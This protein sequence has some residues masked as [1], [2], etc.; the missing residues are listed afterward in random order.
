MSKK[1][2]ISTLLGASL[3]FATWGYF[4][5]QESDKGL[6]VKASFNLGTG[7]NPIAF[8]LGARYVLGSSFEISLMDIGF[9]SGDKIPLD[10]ESYGDNE[11]PTNSGL[12]NPVL[13]VRYQFT[14]K[15]GAFVD[16]AIPF[17]SQEFAPGYIYLGIQKAF[18]LNRHFA[19][20]NEVGYK[21]FFA[22]SSETYY[23]DT[24]DVTRGS[25]V[26]VATEL[27]F[28]KNPN[29]IWFVG[30]KVSWNISETNGEARIDGAHNL[31]EEGDTGI[32][33]F[34]GA[35]YKINPNLAIE[36]EFSMTLLGSGEFDK[37]GLNFKTSAK[38]AF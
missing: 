10:L 13:G 29:F 31:G 9:V 6:Q 7:D 23:G 37:S 1:I 36:E 20:G 5:L 18:T 34:A 22:V 28:N 14:R 32:D 38:Y 24:E 15:F 8:G 16:L 4:P 11:L 19:W 21:S 3:S 26:L 27:D 35:S 30:G 25:Q 33:V 17:D 2:I 12:M